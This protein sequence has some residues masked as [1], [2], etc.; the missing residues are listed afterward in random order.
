M[1]TNDDYLLTTKDNK[2]NPFDDYDNWKNFDEE[3]MHYCTEAYTARVVAELALQVRNIFEGEI[4]DT[5]LLRLRNQAFDDIIKYN[6]E[7]GY[8]IYTKISRDGTREDSSP[9]QY[10]EALKAPA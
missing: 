2:F 9:S 4:S 7:I 3:T 6:N 8:D 1:A 5:D 10:L